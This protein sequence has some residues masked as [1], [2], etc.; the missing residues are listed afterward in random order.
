LRQVKIT[1]LKNDIIAK[2]N[3]T[4]NSYGKVYYKS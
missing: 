2:R 4:L 3:Y 1:S